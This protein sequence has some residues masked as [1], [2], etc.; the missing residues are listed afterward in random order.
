MKLK[1][2]FNQK[3]LDKPILSD[4]VLE[5]KIPLN[6]LEA[7][8]TPREGEL[9]VDVPDEGNDLKKL[10]KIFQNKGVTVKQIIRTIEIDQ[11]ICISCGACT[12]VCS[13]NAIIQKPDW[14]VEFDEEKCVVCRVCIHSCPVAAISAL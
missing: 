12:S 11:D 10:I 1:L 5:T 4:V 14:T 3:N 2:I 13:F 7:K 6:I 9:V 8:I